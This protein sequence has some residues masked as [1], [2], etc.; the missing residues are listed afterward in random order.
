VLKVAGLPTTGNK[1]ALIAKI[2]MHTNND[3]HRLKDLLAKT[4][5]TDELELVNIDVTED[6]QDCALPL[7]SQSQ[8]DSFIGMIPLASDTDADSLAVAVSE[9]S[10]LEDRNS[11]SQ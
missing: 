2:M 7:S 11:S 6:S 5:L 9:A 8:S 3:P 1:D 10:A 4:K